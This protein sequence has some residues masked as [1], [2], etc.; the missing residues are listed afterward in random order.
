MD[1]YENLLYKIKGEM[2]NDM[3]LKKEDFFCLVKDLKNTAILNNARKF[4]LAEAVWIEGGWY[5]DAHPVKIS[6]I[7][8]DIC[9]D[10]YADVNKNFNECVN[11][12]ILHERKENYYE[13]LDM[14]NSIK[15]PDPSKRIHK[16]D[17]YIILDAHDLGWKIKV[18]FITSD[19]ELLAF[20]EILKEITEIDEMT[21]LGDLS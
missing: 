12:L 13:L 20:K 15:L 18:N 1:D 6:K 10:L 14:I 5:E 3:P 11:S 19:K 7:L 17:N 21:Y 4:N 9:G 16:H 2:T 8:D